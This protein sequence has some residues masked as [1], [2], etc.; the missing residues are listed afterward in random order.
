[1]GLQTLGPA[2]AALLSLS[3]AKAWLRVGHASEDTAITALIT[4]A[5][6][7]VEAETGRALLTRTFRETLD[8]WHPRRLS[9]C[10]SAFALAVAPA[11]SVE[12]VRTFDR[13]GEETLWDEAE[14][15]VDTSAD[16]GRLIA[17]APFAF[18]RP[19]RL[20]AGIEI[21][22]SAG[23]GETAADVPPA[24]IEA[25]LRLVAEGY[26]ASEPALAA[27]RGPARLPETVDSLLRPFRQVRL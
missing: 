5:T 21:D 27:G 24:L 6:A 8:S 23:Y 12:A 4:T 15:R 7:R 19:G 22:F 18:P 3:E 1:M 13:A 14:Y 26:A 2:P 20:A 9:G 11:V 10:G 25:I 17:R 16:P